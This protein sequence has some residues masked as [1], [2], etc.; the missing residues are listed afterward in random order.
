MDTS[1]LLLRLA[2]RTKRA[3]AQWHPE[4]TLQNNAVH[5]EGERQP[6]FRFGPSS[7]QA[8]IKLS[9]W[10]RFSTAIP[11]EPWKPEV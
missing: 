11:P 10:H 5:F 2:A 6:Y 1:L 4:I 3:D 7:L 9:K 8:A